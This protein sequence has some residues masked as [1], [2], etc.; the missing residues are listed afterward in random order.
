MTTPWVEKYRPTAFD[1]VVGNTKVVHMLANL[2]EKDVSIPNLLLC[3]PSGSGKTTCVDIVCGEIIRG[4]PHAKFLRSS[5]FEERGIDY[6]RSTVKNFAKERFNNERSP[7]FRP[8]FRPGPGKVVVLDEADSIAPGAFQALRRVME[9][10][11]NTTRF[12]IVC[13][14]STKIIEPIQS[15]CAILRFSKVDEAA[16]CSRMSQICDT[17]GVEYDVGGIRALACVADGDLRSAINSLS[18]TVSA[19]YSVTERNVYRTCDAPQPAKIEEILDLLR[20]KANYAR[21]CRKLKDVVDDGYHASDIVSTFFTASAHT[22]VDKEHVRLEVAKVIGLTQARVLNG[23][24]SYLQL[25]AM[26]WG[27]AEVLSGKHDRHDI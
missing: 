27:I 16:V 10:F 19:F 7:G 17:A 13:N 4:N 5:S 24:A 3:G 11:S 6:V 8:G 12:I 26:L 25:A 18:S 20:S 2:L 9:V 14:N 22:P 23:V 1:G 21:A 15:R